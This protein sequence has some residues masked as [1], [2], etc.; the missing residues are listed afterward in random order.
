MDLF[1]DLWLGMSVALSPAN[2]RFLTIGAMVGMVVGIIP[3]FGPSAGIAILMPLTFGMDPIGAVVML[4]AIYYGAHVRRHHHLDPAQHAGR[5]GDGRHALSTAILWPR[6][7]RRPALVMAAV[8]LVHRRHGRR[9]PDHPA[10]AAV[11]PA[12]RSFGPPASSCSR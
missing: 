5:V 10:R 6:R 12:H 8:G 4:A 2:H 9:D 7:P 1:A 11:Q 3:G